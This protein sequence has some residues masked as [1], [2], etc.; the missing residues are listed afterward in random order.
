VALRVPC[1]WWQPPR[2]R[3]EAATGTA[4]CGAKMGCGG[5]QMSGRERR[6]AG[7]PPGQ[8]F[9]PG[10]EGRARRPAAGTNSSTGQ[11]QEARACREVPK[12]PVQ[13][14]SGKRHEP[15]GR[16]PEAAAQPGTTAI[17]RRING[18]TKKGAR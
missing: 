10:Q 8:A 12:A 17:T 7:H 1:G 9:G 13:P 11:R 16:V 5:N 4:A 14:A 18:S 15:A 3:R 2:K 6:L